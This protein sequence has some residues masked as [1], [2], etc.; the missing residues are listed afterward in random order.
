[1]AA[2][3]LGTG[4]RTVTAEMNITPLVDVMLV[5]LVIFM[6]A[7]PLKTQRLELESSPCSKN[8]PQP[9][10]PVNL[11]IKQTG[12][13]Y[14]NGSPINRAML[15]ANLALLSRQADAPPVL[16]RPEARTRYA[17]VTDLLAAARNADVR[18][19]SLEPVNR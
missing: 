19:I 17:L 1:M 6:L 15:A 8:C 13:L 12:E 18:K 4:I 2:F 10:A 9:P 3:A 16:V 14:W 7:V 11:S 5:L